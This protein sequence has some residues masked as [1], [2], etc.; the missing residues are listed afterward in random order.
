MKKIL[1]VGDGNHQFIRTLV[2]NLKKKEQIKV[3]CL[4]ISP[5]DSSKE[6]PYDEIIYLFPKFRFKP[7]NIIISIFSCYFFLYRY[8]RKYDVIHFQYAYYFYARCHWVL[9]KKI[10]KILTIWG[11]DYYLGIKKEE[12]KKMIPFLKKMDII[13]FTSSGT[14]KEFNE[15]FKDLNCNTKLIRFGLTPLDEIKKIKHYSKAESRKILNLEDKFTVTVGYSSTIVH[16]HLAIFK[17]L[18]KVLIDK[19][20]NG[21]INFLLPLTYGFSDYRK[22][23]IK[24]IKNI[25]L[26]IT[27]FV[28]YMSNNEVA[29]LR[30]ASEIM[31]Q[32]RVT[33]QFSGSMQEAMVTNNMVITGE[34]LP[35]KDLKSA[36]AYYQTIEKVEDVGKV[37]LDCYHNYDNNKP[38][39]EKNSEIIFN[40]S[41]WENNI[42]NWINL[43]K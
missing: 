20:I 2:E 17:S 5:F 9:Y 23:I 30:N 35:Y 26:H 4:S 22:Q 41:S 37:F 12:G 29:H 6:Y 7:I 8:S 19:N 10:K 28:D 3:D 43:Y 39:L 34:W 13:N 40:L 42:D 11:S 38:L 31:I 16:Q 27:P 32:L 33:D 14:L 36:G 1:M 21:K 15:K 25:K 24:Q 18:E